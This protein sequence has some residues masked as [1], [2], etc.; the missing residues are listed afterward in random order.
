MF[1]HLIVR[2]AMA[3][4]LLAASS[5]VRAAFDL[6]LTVTTPGS[7]NTTQRAALDA[8][9]AEAESLWERV[10]TGYQS[11]ISRT[12]ISISIEGGS[13]FADA[14]LTGT[15]S[16]G[17]FQIATSGRIR[18]NAEVIDLFA[19]W[20]GT[21][22]PVNPPPQYLG[23]NYVDEI[24]AHEIGHVLG[25]GTLWV[26]NG[27]YA[28]NSFQYT[29]QY[30]VGAYRHEFDPLAT[31][32][33][34]ENAGGA[35]TPNTHWNQLMRSSSQEG[36]PL[37]P[38]SLDPRI[39]ITNAAGR[40]FASELMTGALDPDY[41]EPFLSMTTI[42]SLRDIGFTVVPEPG[43]LVLCITAAGVV[44]FRR[45]RADWQIG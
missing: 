40:D 12:G 1:R 15:T 20:N 21:P 29:G 38:W 23:L 32:V 19:A 6:T 35:G 41:G 2:C 22:G 27:V 10:I 7:F 37:D 28:F 30:G 16:Q 36:N 33:P 11:G 26:D 25:I 8:A 34:V 9:L 14:T 42:Q 45:S 17:G 4:L 13:S 39:G 43:T 24:L 44:F 5:E 3:M 31:F 18:I